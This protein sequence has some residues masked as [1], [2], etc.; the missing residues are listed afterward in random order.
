M[1]DITYPPEL[2]PFPNE[3]DDVEILVC[4]GLPKCDGNMGK[5]CSDCFNP[6]DGIELGMED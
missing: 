3:G 6:V 1:S 5:P 2:L 4:R